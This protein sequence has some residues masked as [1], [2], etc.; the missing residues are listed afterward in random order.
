MRYLK[1]FNP[2]R[3]FALLIFIGA[4]TFFS[5]L[6]AFGKDEGTLGENL[7]LNFM[8]DAYAFFRFPSHVLFWKFM[9]GPLFFIGLLINIIFYTFFIELVIVFFKMRTKS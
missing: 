6:T 9:Q 8:A 5:F 4:L 1:H 2:A 7:F 3:F